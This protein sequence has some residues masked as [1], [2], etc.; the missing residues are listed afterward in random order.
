MAMDDKALLENDL[1]ERISKGDKIQQGETLPAGYRSELLRLMVVFVDSQLAGAAGF[2]NMINFGPGLRERRNAAQIVADRF[3]HAE[4]VLDLLKEFNVEPRLYV[5]SHAWSSR[6]DRTID[7]GN[8]R[9]GGDKRLNVFH[10]PIEGWV[11]ALVL[12]MLMGTAS[13]VQLGEL[14]HASY[15]PLAAAMTDIV[16][17]EQSHIEIGEKGLQDAIDHDGL[18]AAQAAV[19]Y[20]Y[21]RVAATF[22]RSDSEH[23][24]RF[25][26]F[27]LMK[28][29]NDERQAAWEG[30]VNDILG[31]LGLE[32]PA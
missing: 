28:Q 24:A 8:R 14:R 18:A 4:K 6:L 1:I 21:P 19:E 29:A 22:G 32:T 27:G 11:D 16:K 26:Q 20:W 9:I 13:V 12:N 3:D 17:S 31:R 23:T 10:Y 25:K 30:Q 7:L 5:S 15:A 2:A